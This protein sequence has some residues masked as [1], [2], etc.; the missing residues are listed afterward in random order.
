MSVDSPVTAS[1]LVH[2]G[3]S[4]PHGTLRT[5]TFAGRAGQ[6]AEAKRLIAEAAV[7]LL[8]T[9]TSIAIDSGT[10]CYAVATA[11]P[12]DFRGTVITHSVP[13]LQ[14]MLLHPKAVVL[15]LGGELMRESQVLIGPRTTAAALELSSDVFFL[16]ANSLDADG[17]Y[18]RG[19][20]SSRSSQPSSSGRPR[21][22]CWPT[23]RN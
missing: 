17:A 20:A 8:S 12:R 19:V 3:V 18:L 22:S 6:K 23:G 5:A 2:G 11:L 21:W 7:S 13:V 9:V 16:G 14:Q 4:L 10:T 1:R 15:G